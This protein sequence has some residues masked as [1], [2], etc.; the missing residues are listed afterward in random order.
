MVQYLCIM[1]T[2]KGLPDRQETLCFFSLFTFF[3]HCLYKTGSLAQTGFK[4]TL[5]LWITSEVSYDHPASIQ[6]SSQV[7]PS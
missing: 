4:L 2:N 3:A 7:L 1:N 5:N 6:D